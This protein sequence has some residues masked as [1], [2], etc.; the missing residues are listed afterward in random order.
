[1]TLNEIIRPRTPAS[2]E[3][4]EPIRLIRESEEIMMHQT[5]MMHIG[6]LNNMYTTFVNLR[7]DLVER[8][9]NALQLILETD[10]KIIDSMRRYLPNSFVVSVYMNMYICLSHSRVNIF[11]RQTKY[12]QP[13]IVSG[14]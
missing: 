1:V 11:G 13:V 3:L 10:Y 2:I 6:S 4:T 12:I 5:T 14:S 9:E 8:A 7:G